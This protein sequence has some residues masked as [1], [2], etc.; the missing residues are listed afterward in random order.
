MYPRGVRPL[1]EGWAKN[2]AVGA[3]AAPPY[4]VGLSA[5]WIAALLASPAL[6]AGLFARSTVAALV[7]YAALAGQVAWVSRRLGRFGAWPVL[8][9]PLTA[10]VFVVLFAWSAVQAHV[11]GSVTWRGR[12]IAVGRPS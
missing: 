6:M 9:Y 5:A 2:L 1:I 11:L 4:A 7:V 12:R 10:A 3:G 8:L